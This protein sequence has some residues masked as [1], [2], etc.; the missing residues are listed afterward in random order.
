MPG[1]RHRQPPRVRLRSLHRLA[2]RWMVEF[3]ELVVFHSAHEGIGDADGQIEVR[4]GACHQLRIDKGEDIGMIYL[5]DPLLAP[6]RLP[7]SLIFSVAQSK[8]F[9]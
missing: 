6:S 3:I 7:P 8:I 4:E 2:C 5:Q 1:G 9:K